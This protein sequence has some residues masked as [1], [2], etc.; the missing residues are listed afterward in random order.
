MKVWLKIKSPGDRRFDSLVPF[1]RV[2][3]WM[4]IFDPQ[5]SEG[6]GLYL[7]VVLLL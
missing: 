7:F 2:P 6:V 3:F 4:P 5:P 1:A